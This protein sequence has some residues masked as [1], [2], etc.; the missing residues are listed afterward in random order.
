ME[1]A[2]NFPWV[3]T[4][5]PLPLA[6]KLLDAG[7]NPN[8]IV[9]NTPRAR[10]ARRV[11]TD[12]LATALMR[13][14]VRRRSRIEQ[15]AP[16]LRRRSE[17]HLEGRRD[18]ARSGRWFGV[19]QGYHRGRPETERLEVVKLFVDLGVDVNQAD[20]YGITALMAAANLGH[21]KVIQSLV[22]KGADLGRMTSARRTMARSGASVEP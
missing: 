11:A 16:V 22:D 18:D 15:A 3:V 10:H 20:D 9:N 13:A 17:D 19:H 7:A 1:T 5:D 8:A 4:E 2:P 6:K 21:T 14:R 12:R